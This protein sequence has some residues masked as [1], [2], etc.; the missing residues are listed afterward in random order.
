MMKWAAP[1]LIGAVAALAT[2]CATV[3]VRPDDASAADH[4]RVASAGGEEATQHVAAAR[5]LE[6]FEAAQCGSVSAELRRDCPLEYLSASVQDVEG[7][8]LVRPDGD[9]SLDELA[10]RMRCHQAFGRTRHFA[11]MSDCPLYL[12]GLKIGTAEHALTITASDSRAADE[13][14]E[15]TH[16]LLEREVAPSSPR[17]SGGGM[18]PSV[19]FSIGS[20]F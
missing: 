9:V 14:R 16:A 17:P 3:G 15:R 4:R 7:G 20:G 5:V 8:V 6:S 12:G 10:N 1:R 11:H 18:S 13:I 19:P 2:A